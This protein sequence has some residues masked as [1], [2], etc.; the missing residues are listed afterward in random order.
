MKWTGSKIRVGIQKQITAENLSG[1]KFVI[2]QQQ[3][4]RHPSKCHPKN[5]NNSETRNDSFENSINEHCR[6][7]HRNSMTLTEEERLELKVL[8]VQNYWKRVSLMIP[9]VFRLTCLLEESPDQLLEYQDL[10]RK[11][12]LAQN[13]GAQGKFESAELLKNEI[14]LEL[15]SKTAQTNLFK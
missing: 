14:K 9:N 13:G 7:E 2:R 11:E 15:K 1:C 4:I 6:S 3:Q 5:E 10:S 12:V 8:K